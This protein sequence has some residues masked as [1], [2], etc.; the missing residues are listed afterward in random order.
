MQKQAE[1]IIEVLICM[2]ALLQLRLCSRTIPLLKTISSEFIHRYENPFEFDPFLILSSSIKTVQLYHRDI[3]GIC[4][5]RMCVFFV[6]IR[7]FSRDLLLRSFANLRKNSLS[8]CF[9]SFSFSS[10]FICSFSSMISIF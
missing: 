5:F 4:L 7:T 1:M 8:F 2:R 9:R 6:H 10:H 3:A